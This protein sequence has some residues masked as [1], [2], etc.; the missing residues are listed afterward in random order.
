MR[1][2]TRARPPRAE[3][4]AARHVTHDCRVGVEADEQVD[5]L[6]RAAAHH[7][8]L[9]LEQDA[10]RCLQL[11]GSPPPPAP[12]DGEYPS[13][14]AIGGPRT[15]RNIGHRRCWLWPAVRTR[16]GAVTTAGCCHES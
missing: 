14:S 1:A 5:V 16:Q 11:G 13:R 4:G 15:V 6:D 3:W 9:G 10:A 12:R 7:Q 2:A 8:P